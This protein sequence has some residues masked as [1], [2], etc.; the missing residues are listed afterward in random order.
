MNDEFKCFVKLDKFNDSS[1][2]ILILCFTS[3]SDWDTYLQIKEELGIEIK[4]KATEIGLNFAFPVL[5]YFENNL[6]REEMK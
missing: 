2:D 4:K 1:I 3:T 5:L 6:K